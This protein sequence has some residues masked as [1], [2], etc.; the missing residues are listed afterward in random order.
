MSK[1]DGVTQPT[2]VG[3][4]LYDYQSIPCLQSSLLTGIT[5]ALLF[6]LINV[7]LYKTSSPSI[8]SVMSGWLVGSIPA[9]FYCRR[10]HRKKT[11]SIWE[12]RKYM[13]TIS[14][15]VPNQTPS[16]TST[17]VSQPEPPKTN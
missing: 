15:E 10:E 11:E 6:G 17:E 12:L 7:R 5:S 2:T 9:W 8:N 1:K 3:S 4:L 14:T 13:K 16:L